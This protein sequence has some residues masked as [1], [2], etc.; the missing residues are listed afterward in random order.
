VICYG[1][2]IVMSRYNCQG[3][4]VEGLKESFQGVFFKWLSKNG[5]SRAPVCS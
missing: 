3:G 1:Y 5:A 2:G 4:V